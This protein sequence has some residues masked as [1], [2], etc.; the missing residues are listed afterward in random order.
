MFGSKRKDA[1][2]FDDFSS[3]AEKSVEAARMLFEMMVWLQPTSE[4]ER[5]PYQRGPGA[6][7]EGRVDDKTKELAVKITEAEAAGDTITH[8]TMKRLRENWLTPLD[9]TDIHELISR[10]D[11]VL[12]AI[13][14]AA[15]R[16][17]LFE[18][19]VAPPEA[20]ELARI[21]VISCEAIVK[22][23]ELLRTLAKAPQILELCA[24]VNHLENEADAVRRKAIAELF[25][26]GNEPVMVMK[27]RDI[28]DSLE[29]A[30][31]RCED[32]ANIVEG[33]VLEYA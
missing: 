32:V 13:E 30:A 4:G 2:F 22:A 17:V 10:M 15:E 24:E 6:S 25:R 1:A 18:I 5:G 14:E 7:S 9:R 19:R 20:R 3:H 33:V 11:D 8:N 27:W 29:S 21:L 16:I 31:D 26:E 23:I 12:D 28:F